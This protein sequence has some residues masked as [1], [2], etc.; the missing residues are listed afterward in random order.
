MLPYVVSCA[1]SEKPS[2]FG[3]Y[4]AKQLAF[5]I[6][7]LRESSL[8][9]PIFCVALRDYKGDPKRLDNVFK[10]LRACEFNLPEYFAVIELF[11]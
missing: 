10:F 5:Y 1:P 9:G 11:M 3:S 6:I 2:D 7:D 4:S 8:D